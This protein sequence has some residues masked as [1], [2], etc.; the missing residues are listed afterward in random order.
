MKNLIAALFLFLFSPLSIAQP[1]IWEPTYGAIL[2][3]VSGEDDEYVAVTLPFAFPFAG[4]DYSTVW[5]ATNGAVQLGALG[6]SGDIDYDLWDHAEEFLSDNAPLISVFNVD[7]EG[8]SGTVHYR[9]LADRI[10]VT[11][12]EL[13]S[14][15]NSSAASTFQLQ[16]LDDGTIILGYN[17]ILDDPG[18]NLVT[19]LDEGITVGISAGAWPSD[20]SEP[21]M[22]DIS[23]AGTAPS[24]YAYQ[25][26]CYD[27]VD[28]CQLGPGL[29]SLPGPTNSS[30]DLDQRNV[31]FTPL[32]GGAYRVSASLLSHAV[33]VNS[34][35]M[36]GTVLCALLLLGIWRIR[37]PSDRSRCL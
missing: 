37:P 6:D 14:N 34:P 20:G 7:L 13:G 21:G 32:P 12:N 30:F 33:P 35:L 24:P 5:V 17:G 3:G 36:L 9:E 2:P 16:L 25:R 28:S 26:W 23:A 19:D 1:P 4:S 29:A 11:W 22:R 10:V 18:Q 27:T 15:V 8:S 31:V